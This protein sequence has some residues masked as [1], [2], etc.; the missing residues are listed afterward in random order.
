[1]QGNELSLLFE[2]LINTINIEE[3]E[4]IRNSELHKLSSTQIHY[5]DLIRHEGNPPLSLLA[6]KLKV[7]KPS[8][9]NHVDKLEK[10]GYIMKVQSEADKRVQFLHLTKKGKEISDLHEQFHD[11]FAEKLAAGLD[12]KEREKL[13]AILKK[14]LD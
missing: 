12:G 10:L 2:K 1:M 13:A 4:Y 6:R 5:L 14:I 9:T 11:I 3:S 8:V 7:T